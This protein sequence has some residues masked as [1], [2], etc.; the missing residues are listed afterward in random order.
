MQQLWQ[1][2]GLLISI[3]LFCHMSRSLLTLRSSCGGLQAYVYYIT[4]IHATYYNTYALYY[5]MIYM[6]TLWRLPGPCRQTA[7][8]QLRRCSRLPA[9]RGQAA[10]AW[11][12]LLLQTVTQERAEQPCTLQPHRRRQPS[13]YLQHK[14]LPPLSRPDT[15]T[16]PRLR[17]EA[18]PGGQSGWGWGTGRALVDLGAVEVGEEGEEGEEG[19]EGEEG[20]KEEVEAGV[21]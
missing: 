21:V 7:L 17:E 4:H 15:P 2:P 9:S 6:L 16:R 18:W 14:L 1:L 13:R 20:G 10:P 3:G 11:A 5:T 19:K 8:S 12:W